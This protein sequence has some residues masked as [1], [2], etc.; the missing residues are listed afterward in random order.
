LACRAF[1]PTAE[2]L[3]EREASPVNETSSER[4]GS[5]SLSGAQTFRKLGCQ[6]CHSG[7][8]APRLD[9]LFG[10]E[11]VL[12]NGESLVADEV[13]LRESILSPREKIVDGLLMATGRLCLSLPTASATPS[14][15]R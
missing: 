13:Y 3:S 5:D 1:S 8:A 14:S 2:R 10:A 4:S 9:G 6:E 11:V 7:A 15:T 12:D